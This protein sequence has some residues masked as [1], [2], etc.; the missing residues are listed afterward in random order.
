[1]ILSLSAPPAGPKVRVAV[2][3]PDGRK[4]ILTDQSFTYQ[5]ARFLATKGS[6]PNKSFLFDELRFDTNTAR[7]TP[8]AQ[9]E[10]NDLVQIMKTYPKLHIRIVGYTDS[11]G[12]ESI[13]KPLSAARANFV[14]VALVK[15]GINTS[16]ITTGKEGEEEPIATNQTAKGRHRNRRVEIVVTRL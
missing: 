3:A 8:D 9:V 15:E 16:R 14:K 2:D 5:L 4:L 10:V 7:I 6:R 13:N 11:V 12:P 1:V